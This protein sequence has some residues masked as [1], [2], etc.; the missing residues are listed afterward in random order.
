MSYLRASTI[1][2]VICR[3]PAHTRKSQP[4]CGLYAK[5]DVLYFPCAEK[6]VL[7]IGDFVVPKKPPHVVETYVELPAASAPSLPSSPL[8]GREDID[9]SLPPPG[10]RPGGVYSNGTPPPPA[11]PSSG[12]ASKKPL[13]WRGC[14]GWRWKALW[15]RGAAARSTAAT[16]RASDRAD[17]PPRRRMSSLRPAAS[18]VNAGPM[19]PRR[20]GSHG[21]AP[22]SRSSPSLPLAGLLPSAVH[23]SPP[24]SPFSASSPTEVSPPPATAAGA[25]GP[26]AVPPADPAIASFPGGGA[27]PACW[28]P[29]SCPLTSTPS[30]LRCSPLVADAPLSLPPP[31]TPV[32]ADATPRLRDSGRDDAPEEPP[33]GAAAGTGMGVTAIVAAE[34]ED[35][36]V[37]GSGSTVAASAAA[38]AA[39]EP[40]DDLVVPFTPAAPPPV[41][42]GPIA[43]ERSCIRA[44]A[45]KD[46]E[47]VQ[48]EDGSGNADTAQLRRRVQYPSIAVGSCGDY[49][50]RES[51]RK[52]RG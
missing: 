25:P 49:W 15:R 2:Q 41:G 5:Q 9:A 24:A 8:P 40:D 33:C 19:R 12:S 22:A 4:T 36:V 38:A 17:S 6:L 35:A 1:G 26:L 32:S 16:V 34:D 45:A 52:F 7:T 14:W 27:T 48:G 20:L 21:S 42:L 30:R 44:A 43:S 11:P 37:D 46:R 29:L 39:D 31:L 28:P 23:P 50:A 13:A 47:E 51:L 10:P 18:L 3:G